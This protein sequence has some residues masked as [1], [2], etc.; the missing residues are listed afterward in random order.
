MHDVVTPVILAGLLL[1]TSNWFLGFES[2]LRSWR[3]LWSNVT[4]VVPQVTEKSEGPSRIANM[5]LK[6]CMNLWKF[7]SSSTLHCLTMRGECSCAVLYDMNVYVRHI[8]MYTGHGQ[9]LGHQLHEICLCMLCGLSLWH[10]ILLSSSHTS[11]NLDA[12]IQTGVAHTRPMSSSRHHAAA[13]STWD[14][15]CLPGNLGTNH[16]HPHA[17]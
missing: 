7:C 9:H 10:R 6:S 1:H 3:K 11:S 4:V 14:I 12:K 5:D 13:Y 17:T 8:W 2:L 16:N 15:E